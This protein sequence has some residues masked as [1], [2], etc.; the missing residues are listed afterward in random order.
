MVPVTGLTPGTTTAYE[1]L[2]DD[3]RVWPLEGSG[4]PPSTIRTPDVPCDGVTISFGSCRW[5]AAPAG[6]HDPVGPDAQIGRAHV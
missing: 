6:E 1:V 4:F 2:L 3:R 5:S